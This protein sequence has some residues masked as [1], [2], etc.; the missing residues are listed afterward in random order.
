MWH[1]D[2]T[3]WSV[4]THFASL[5]AA[6]AGSCSTDVWAVT[7][8]GY[9][10]YDGQN[11]ST[12]VLAA[13]PNVT[14]TF[15]VMALA[16]AD[17]WIGGYSGPDNHGLILHRH[18][19]DPTPVCGNY[20]LDPG[21][22]CDPPN[23]AHCDPT[24]QRRVVCGDAFVDPPEQCDPP[25]P[26]VCDPNCRLYATCG[27]GL[28]D[29]GEEC[30]PPN[31]RGFPICD[32]TC[33]INLCGNW[34]IDP[35][36][37]CDPPRQDEFGPWCDSTCQVPRCG[38]TVIDPGEE[39]DPPRALGSAGVPACDQTCHIPTCGNLTIDAG[40]QCDPPDDITCSRTCQTLAPFCGNGVVEPGESCEYSA[41][42]LC[43]NCQPTQCG[44][45]FYL[46]GGAKGCEGLTG[47]DKM[48]CDA[49]TSC[50]ALCDRY[51][52]DHT[53]CYCVDGV[54]PHG[55][56]GAC[57]REFEAVAHSHDPAVVLS[58][59]PDP[60]TRV[61]A[62][63]KAVSDFHVAPCKIACGGL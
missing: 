25:V 60:T 14:T 19:G 2:G 13:D 22:Q 58:Q 63:V 42:V 59:I 56:T 55:P 28:V 8:A 41:S 49:L 16:G 62:V 21:E 3:S 4:P 48:S 15:R 29:P 18:P 26:N 39:C 38:N 44:M 43:Q 35:G 53:F 61:G 37:A 52:G 34:Q 9:V 24:C 45:C 40:E 6:L 20:R 10:H 33:H 32:S 7:G 1:F 51:G 50:L 31:P 17:V 57:S 46:W 36:E 54:C 30:D 5:A 11:W 23:T 47:R 12:T 27:N